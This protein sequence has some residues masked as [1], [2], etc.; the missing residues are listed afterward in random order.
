MHFLAKPLYANGN[1]RRFRNS[2]TGLVFYDFCAGNTFTGARMIC[3]LLRH[4]KK[5]GISANSHKVI[6]T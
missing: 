3:E 1:Q 2:F 6:R 4:G 5:V